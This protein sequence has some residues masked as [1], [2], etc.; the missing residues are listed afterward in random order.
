MPDY[1]PK[2]YDCLAGCVENYATRPVFD[3]V[4]YGA[5]AESFAPYVWAQIGD[6]SNFITVGNDS[7]PS[8]PNKAAIKS[9]EFGFIDANEGKME[10]IDEEGGNLSV[11]LDSV[12][13][14]GDRFNSNVYLKIRVGWVL[15]LCD[16]AIAP[17][18]P[19][20]EIRALIL[21]ISSNLSNGIIKF[22]VHFATAHPV[23]QNRRQDQTFGQEVGGKAMP[24]EDAISQLAQI[25]PAINVRY[26]YWDSDGELKD[27]E[28]KWKD[29]PKKGPKAAWQGDS[30]NKYATIAK[31]LEG[32]V[33]DDGVS[34]KGVTLIHDPK[35]PWDLVVLRD[36]QPKCGEKLNSKLNL[37]TFIVNG[38]KCSSVLEFSPSYDFVSASGYFASG[39]STNPSSS[40]SVKKE[41]AR[42]ETCQR[43]N[44]DGGTQTQVT[45]NNPSNYTDG[46]QAS[47]N[48]NKAQEDHAK[49]NRL[50]EISGVT[51]NADLRIVGSVHPKLYQIVT[52]QRCSIVV[53]NPNFISGG[54]A[55]E[56][57]GDFLKRAD[58]HPFYSNKEWIIMGVNHT[59]QEGSFVT[60][61]KVM[62]PSP[63]VELGAGNNLGA[64]DSGGADPGGC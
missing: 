4:P 39:G 59:I 8:N 31:W 3:Q 7:Y 22:T 62:L 60:T 54:V 30:Q 34:S 24:L 16:G 61:L 28:F 42:N 21:K 52:G 33:V 57:C 49:A 19:S 2:T 58:C 25:P 11:F 6:G 23:V 55:G 32:Y 43:Q 47:D 18:N 15:S 26:C 5:Q 36:S 40:K 12:Q 1:G 27:D 48:V 35:N 13:K 29:H 20:P 37:G 51:I 17:A 44:K 56:S 64:N 41:D 38:G 46:K 53:I 10:I 14:C 45:I 9:I 63:A 50:V